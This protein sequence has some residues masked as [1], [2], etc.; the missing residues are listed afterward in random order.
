VTEHELGALINELRTV[1]DES[2]SLS[3]E[4]RTRLNDLMSRVET[5]ADEDDG[6]V[7][8]LE[9]AL[10]QFETEHIDLVRII[11]RIANVLSAGGI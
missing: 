4:D 5:G 3:D 6:I 2:K 7:D 11:N 10:S 9:D 8:H 1:I